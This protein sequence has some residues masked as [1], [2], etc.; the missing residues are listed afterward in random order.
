MKTEDGRILFE[1]KPCETAAHR[2]LQR[3][4]DEGFAEKT[5]DEFVSVPSGNIYELDRGEMDS[6]GLPEFYPFDILVKTKGPYASPEFCFESCWMT[7]APLGN[8]LRL[9]ERDEVFARL[10]VGDE[11]IE[12]MLTTG[13]YSLLQ[14][15]DAF[16]SLPAEEKTAVLNC[17]RI[18][19]IQKS[20]RSALAV[21]DKALEQ[22]K[23]VV[24]ERVKLK[25]DKSENGFEILP[26]IKN[27]DSEKFLQKFDDDDSVSDRYS[28]FENGEKKIVVLDEP[29]RK[30]LEK[31]KTI[32]DKVQTNSDPKALEDFIQDSQKY[33]D[34]EYIDISELYSERVIGIG[35][36]KPKV[37]PFIS[38]Y[39]SD[40]IPTFVIAEKAQDPNNPTPKKGQTVSIKNREELKKFKKSYAQA[41][42]E[43][44]PSVKFGE[45]EIPIDEI[46]A[47]IEH[48]EKVFVRQ[49]K[50]PPA[51]EQVLIIKENMEDE[52]FGQAT[53]LELPK[54]LLLHEDPALKKEIT[55]KNYQQEGIAWLQY[56][57]REKKVGCLLADDMG[58]GKTLQVLYLI[59]WHYRTQ[60]SKKPYLIVAPVILLE[61]WESEFQKFFNSNMSVH[62]IERIPKDGQAAENFIQEHSFKHLMIMS[63]ECMRRGQL[64]LGK[65]DFSIIAMDEA[66]KIKEPG[67]LVTNAAKALKGDFKIAMTG[68][69]VENTFM[70]LWCVVDFSVPGLLGCAK[71][72]AK[73]F[74]APL[75]KASPEEI[76]ALGEKLHG[77]LGGY[78]L[79]R[80]KT[81]V[82]KDLPSKTPIYRRSPMPKVQFQ[83]YWNEIL[84]PTGEKYNGLQKIQELK[85]ISDHPD[86]GEKN[87]EDLSVDDLIEHSAK[88]KAT[89]EILEEI[90][91]KREK[92]IIF[93]ERR[94]MQKML[95][96]IVEEKF[97]LDASVINGESSRTT[98]GSSGSRQATID[99][100]QEKSGFN[101]IIM[102][103]L[104]A[105][106][107]LNVV[108][109]NHVIHYTRHWNP[110]NEN[111]ATDRVYRIG[112]EKPV[113]IYYP[114]AVVENVPGIEKFKTFDEV[115]NE[116]LERK[117]VLAKSSLY[118][119]D[120][121]EVKSEDFKEMLNMPCAP[122]ENSEW[123][124][125]KSVD[126]MDDF[127]FEAFAAACFRKRGFDV[128]LT[129]RSGDHGVDVLASKGGEN[130]AIQCKHLHLNTPKNRIG[131]IAVN[132]VYAG[133]EH[134]K[135]F[136]DLKPAVWTNGKFEMG[137]VAHAE[138]TKTVLFDRE[139]ILQMLKENPVSW[140]DVHNCE[141]QRLLVFDA[142][143]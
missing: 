110:A 64:T 73:V 92:V 136:P 29:L 10:C 62:C 121:I 117:I 128:T 2:T 129:P 88:L 124:S 89:M 17:I 72:F 36:Y 95:Q 46:P 60:Q 52:D 58:L 69:P 137:A 18:D 97:A 21:L 41:L 5:S 102:S 68:T 77:W 123:L 40:W 109:A 33:L 125:E 76:D 55:L 9:V 56:L 16:N 37:Y 23:I 94:E 49:P 105:G 12:Y 65:I 48:A 133:K 87:W 3:L 14:K 24:P 132:E 93:T 51:P 75:K 118:P 7:S 54:K 141:H 104:A 15:I 63:Y 99:R 126:E 30:E 101:V 22:K 120:Q 28:I 13:Q 35:L 111:Q 4:L 20:S 8:Y 116:L 25:F 143:F 78:F 11:E 119:T 67:T 131:K 44:K 57:M 81:D 59:D 127:L 43:G 122:S 71:D 34:P 90:R 115:L 103:P 26:E 38:Q 114:M 83:R 135:S 84:R 106:V 140:N 50:E 80:L 47:M 53:S 42:E 100:F 91:S 45:A 130:L 86:F 39:K 85:K 70:N 139:R 61:N 112:Q 1:L 66:Q 79:R 98:K 138:A 107:G 96:K 142:D 19:E 82:A 27:V 32:R 74:Q 31:V 134:Y 108:G 113:F 6:L